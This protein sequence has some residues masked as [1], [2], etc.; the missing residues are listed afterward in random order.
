ML[1]CKQGPFVFRGHWSDWFHQFSSL[2]AAHREIKR[3]TPK[4]W[5][6]G[7]CSLCFSI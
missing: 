3:H 2:T 6:N 4:V 1:I 5:G 7:T